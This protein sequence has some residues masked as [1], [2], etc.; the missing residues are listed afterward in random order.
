MQVYV[1]ASLMSVCILENSGAQLKRMFEKPPPQVTAATKFLI[2]SRA[3]V[4][5]TLIKAKGTKMNLFTN[6][7]EMVDTDKGVCLGIS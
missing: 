4:Y 6:V 5:P 2:L 7:R 1:H 3:R